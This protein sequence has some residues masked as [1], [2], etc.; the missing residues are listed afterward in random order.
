[1]TF[2]QITR[3]CINSN[4]QCVN[5][6]YAFHILWLIKVEPLKVLFP[7]EKIIF[8]KTIFVLCALIWL[9]V[10]RI[11]RKQNLKNLMYFVW[12]FCTQF[13]FGELVDRSVILLF[14][15]KKKQ[16][17]NNSQT[18]FMSLKHIYITMENVYFKKGPKKDMQIK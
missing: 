15:K 4:Q 9:I 12:I 7:S 6:K 3:N 13:I 5:G 16:Q 1:M 11:W 17:T 8:L 10:L 2:V 14:Y 18:L